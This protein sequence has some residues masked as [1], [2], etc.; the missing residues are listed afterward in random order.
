VN[1]GGL[2]VRDV[3]LF[4]GGKSMGGRMTSLAQSQK[5]LHGLRGIVFYGFPLHPSG[6]PGTTRAEH[7]ARV[8]VP[9]LFLQ[10]TRDRL[11]TR[12]LLEP[13]LAGLGRQATVQWLAEGDHDFSVPKRT[14]MDG[15][16]V[17]AWLADHTL[18]WMQAV[19][20]TY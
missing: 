12:S 3:P 19:V 11:A 16:A 15:P 8:N 13:V 18:A 9:L 20:A 2:I 6:N 4:A 10:G 7:L 5:P 17:M 1:S 14:G